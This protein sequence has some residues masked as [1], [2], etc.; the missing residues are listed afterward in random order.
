MVWIGLPLILGCYVEFS[1]KF[2][3][4]CFFGGAGCTYQPGISGSMFILMYFISYLGGGLLIRYAEGATYLA[5]VQVR[6]CL[7]N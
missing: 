6:P 4:Q 2:A 5:V 7:K 1:Y 3:F